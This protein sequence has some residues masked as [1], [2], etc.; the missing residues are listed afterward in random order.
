MCQD[1][2]SRFLFINC[3]QVNIT[4]Q[5]FKCSR[6]ATINYVATATDN[7]LPPKFSSDEYVKVKLLDPI[8]FNINEDRTIATILAPWLNLTIVITKYGDNLGV[9]LR[10]PADLGRGAEGLCS[11][12]CPSHASL[13][14]VDSVKEES[15]YHDTNSALYGCAITAD[16][17]SILSGQVGDD[18]HTISEPF[19][20]TCQFNV[21]QSLSYSVLSFL[22]AIAKQYSLLPN[23]APDIT[24]EPFDPDLTFP[25]VEPD[26]TSTA[27]TSTTTVSTTPSSSNKGPAHHHHHF[28]SYRVYSWSG[29]VDE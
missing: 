16:L 8:D 12:S 1:V 27:G 15:C 5:D 7:Q 23:V 29:D 17:Y 26:P 14:E 19:V 4:L 24:P 11:S 9:V 13:D 25:P 10:M 18:V 2:F 3:L 20:E 22:R 28:Q 21:L 6:E